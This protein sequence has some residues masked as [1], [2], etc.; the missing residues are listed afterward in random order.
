[1]NDTASVQ[2][3]VARLRRERNK[4]IEKMTDVDSWLATR[5]KNAKSPA[6]LGMK[7]RMIAEKSALMSQALK[8]KSQIRGCVESVIERVT[9]SGLDRVGYVNVTDHAVLRWLERAHNLNL[10][11]VRD[12]MR[13]EMKAAAAVE[14]NVKRTMG[15]GLSVRAGD[16]IYI[17]DAID[18]TIITCYKA[19]EENKYDYEFQ[20][21]GEE[22]EATNNEEV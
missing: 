8:L 1:M 12:D 5:G 2:I 7:N 11:A 21:K 16:M 19:K 22:N 4:I 20:H 6:E 13:D 3:E 9:T 18:Q 17:I 14:G 15:K 10:E